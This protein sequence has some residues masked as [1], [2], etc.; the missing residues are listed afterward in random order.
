MTPPELE[1]IGAQIILGNTYHLYLRP[2]A[3]LVAEAG[4]LHRFMG[5]NRPILTDS[6]GFQ[7]FSLARLNTVTDRGVRCRSHLD[8]SEHEM[9][10]EWAMRVQGLLGSDVAMCFDQCGPFPATHDQAEAALERTTLWAERCRAAHTRQD[11][12]L[13]GIVQGSVYDDLRLRSAREITAMDFPGYRIGGLEPHGYACGKAR[14][15][16]QIAL[17]QDHQRAE[18][19]KLNHAQG[20]Q[21]AQ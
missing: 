14:M 3:E 7:V 10:P 16:A 13:F 8:G 9:S 11:Q 12:A 15:A 17:P 20:H 18:G 19:Q 2:G 6:G 1:T 21:H 5:W 4:G